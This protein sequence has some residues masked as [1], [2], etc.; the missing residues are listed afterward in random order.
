[1]EALTMRVLQL[2]KRSVTVLAAV[3]VAL[4]GCGESGP[5]VSFNPTATSEDMAA[6]NATFES[7]TFLS[8]T[9][10]GPHFD[11]AL[12]GSPLVSASASAF[13]LRRATNDGGLRAAA[14]RSV[15]RLASLTPAIAKG[16][17]SASTAAIPAEIAGKTF[18]YSGGAYAA[19]DRAGAPANGVRFILYDVNPVTVTPVEPLVETG[20]VE[21]TDLS[22]TNI[23]AARVVVVS[24][25]TTYLDYTVSVTASASSGQVTVAGF[26]TDGVYLANVTL[27]S[28]VTSIAGLTL[29]YTVAVPQRDVSIDLT[30]TATGLEQE[31]GNLDINLSM[32]GP[33]GTVSMIGQFTTSGGTLTVRSGGRVFATITVS[34]DT[35]PV[36]TGA[37]G[38]PVTEDDATALRSVFDLTGEA[39]I[40]FDQMLAPATFFLE[41]AA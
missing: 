16:G 24:G 39:F 8:L 19:T 3:G 32:S 36:I 40:S 33:N 10:F 17:F 26:I 29:H 23:H 28:T 6:L 2:V 25:A 1:M 9:W 12:G 30:M 27:R 5:D 14:V 20:Y 31:N 35:D 41:P 15:R 7:P 11:A 38:Q 22:G 18:E 37:N 34:G 21:L 4:T 13:D